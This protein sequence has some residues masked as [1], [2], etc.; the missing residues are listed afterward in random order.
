[1]SFNYNLTETDIDNIGFKSP[2]EQQIQNQEM[3][4][5]AWRFDAV[6][7]L[8]FFFQNYWKGGFKLFKVPLRTS[9]SWILKIM[10]SI[11]SVCQY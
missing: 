2:L 4:D 5:G 7:S 8:T 3:K 6:N 1:M 10:I 9:A 11:I